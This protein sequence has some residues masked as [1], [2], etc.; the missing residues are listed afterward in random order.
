MSHALIKLLDKIGAIHEDRLVQYYPRV[1]DMDDIAVLRCT[2]SD[3]I[4]LSRI[5]HIE[6]GSYYEDRV[7]KSAVVFQGNEL[8]TPRLADNIRRASEYGDVIRGR[9]WMDFGCGLGGMLDEMGAEALLAVGLEPNKDRAAI[10]SQKGHQVFSSIET[11]ENGSFNIITMFHVLEHITN[12]LVVLNALRE[13]LEPN[14]LL[15]VEIPHARD[16]LFTLYDCDAFKKFTFWSEHLVLHT[17]QSL[18]LLLIA[19]G[20]V[21]IEISGYQRYPLAN[22]LYWLAK[23]GPGGQNK[24]LGLPGGIGNLGEGASYDASLARI[25]RTD[26][27]I[28]IARAPSSGES[29]VL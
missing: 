26:T 11:V 21:D 12:P 5:D 3:V 16:A 29:K 2:F 15:V 14:G 13:R 28:A 7:E 24:W 9:R 4:L 20:F 27:L 6:S 10:V 18:N 1:R 17:R 23:G 22:H 25:D 8:V 19:A